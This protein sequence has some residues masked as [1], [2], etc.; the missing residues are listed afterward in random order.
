M[1]KGVHYTWS[2][3]IFISS[4]FNLS[5]EKYYHKKNINTQQEQNEYRIETWYADVPE[6]NTNLGLEGKSL[7][8][9]PETFVTA[10]IATVTKR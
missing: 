2:S 1:G 4:T 5:K 3:S 7:L 6:P 8:L 10:R 9:Y